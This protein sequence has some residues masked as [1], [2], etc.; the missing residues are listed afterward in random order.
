MEKMM[1]QV[2]IGYG[3][4]QA[5]Q[6]AVRLGNYLERCGINCFVASSDPRWIMAGHTLELI[7]TK[8]RKSDIMVVVCTEETDESEKLKREVNYAKK[9][10]VTIIPFVKE[11][12][13]PPFGLGDTHWC[14]YFPVERP[15]SVHSRMVLYI[16]HQMEIRN[17]EIP[18]I[19]E[20]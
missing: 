3:G 10:N 17:E 11:G 12:V 4:E 5:K 16:L 9:N 2:F 18:L 14:Q 20:A 15:W 7:M 1:F 8:L 19:E 6:V 13:T